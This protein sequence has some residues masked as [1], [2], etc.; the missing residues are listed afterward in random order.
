MSEDFIPLDSVRQEKR[1]P[2]NVIDPIQLQGRPIP[3][4]KWLV[5]NWIPHRNVT[6]L[7]GDGGLGKS[8]L[9]M[10]LLTAC[11]TGHP[12]CCARSKDGRTGTL[13][14]LWGAGRGRSSPGSA[15]VR[16]SFVTSWNRIGTE[17][18]DER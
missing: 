2:L 15:A 7:G 8:L 4:R 16:R 11:A 13:L 17:T 12:W 9:A 3:E 18:A 5:P 14:A 1:L 10:Q 6:M